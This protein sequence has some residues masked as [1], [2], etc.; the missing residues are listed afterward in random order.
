MNL[1]ITPEGVIAVVTG[2]GLLA[3]V[4][5][6]PAMVQHFSPSINQMM[7]AYFARTDCMTLTDVHELVDNVMLQL[8]VHL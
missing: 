3:E 7:V 6:N 8:K 5:N 1:D 2:L 4:S